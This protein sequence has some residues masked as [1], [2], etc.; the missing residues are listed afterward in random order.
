MFL[1]G[2]MTP[3]VV[4][5]R[6]FKHLQQ[7]QPSRTRPASTQVR[8]HTR[9]PR[10]PTALTACSKLTDGPVELN[11][12]WIQRSKSNLPGETSQQ[13]ERRDQAAPNRRTWMEQMTRLDSCSLCRDFRHQLCDIRTTS[14]HLPL[15]VEGW[16]WKCLL[17]GRRSTRRDLYARV[18]LVHGDCLDRFLRLRKIRTNLKRKPEPIRYPWIEKIS[19]SR[20][21]Y[22][23]HTPQC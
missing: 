17:K 3:V 23:I 15:Q 6:I 13:Y 11:P 4:I 19:K 7:G 9:S 18:D 5:S 22:G 21:S 1:I 10:F 2:P 12:Q 8:V 20:P 14:S 16:S